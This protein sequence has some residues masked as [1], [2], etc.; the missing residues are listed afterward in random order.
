[1]AAESALP[2]NNIFVMRQAPTICGN[3]DFSAAAMDPLSVPFIP[4]KY[5]LYIRD[6]RVLLTLK[7]HE[8]DGH[9]LVSRAKTRKPVTPKLKPHPDHSD[10]APRT[11]T[12]STWSFLVA[13]NCG[14]KWI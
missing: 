2:K 4:C 6:L 9:I 12:Y 11:F 7:L 10:H 3:M 5:S 8:Q 14:S 1:M 13:P